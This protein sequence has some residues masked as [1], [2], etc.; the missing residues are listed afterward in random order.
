MKY[1]RCAYGHYYDPSKHDSCPHCAAF[2]GGSEP[3]MTVAKSAVDEQVIKAYHLDAEDSVPAAEPAP[4]KVSALQAAPA[5]APAAEDDD[6]VTVARFARQ[7]GFDPPV[8]WLVETAGPNRGA[9]FVIHAQRNTIGRQ[10]GMD[11]CLKGDVGVSRDTNAVLSFDPR[12]RAFHLIPGEGKAIVYL[13][14][15]ELLAPAALKA[16]DRIEISETALLFLPLCG[17]EFSWE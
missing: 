10:T 8:G 16:Y 1:V 7:E 4:Q 11:V 5:A 9:S 12:S 14:G 2:R 3:E 17:D 6:P 13:N 15:A